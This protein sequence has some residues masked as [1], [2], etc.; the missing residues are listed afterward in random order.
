M[1]TQGRHK[2]KPSYMKI[3]LSFFFHN[4][5]NNPEQDT[6]CNFDNY[7][8]PEVKQNDLH[9]SITLLVYDKKDSSDFPPEITY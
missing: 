9:I 3:M 2:E 4:M 7:P 5:N 1:I 8:N 6:D